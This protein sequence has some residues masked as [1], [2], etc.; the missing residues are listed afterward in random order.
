L[1]LNLYEHSLKE[2][3][4][5]EGETITESRAR[6]MIRQVLEGLE[7]L[8]AREP[9]I[10]HRD[11]KPTNIL[12]DVHGNL[13]LSDFGIGRFFPEQGIFTRY[14]FNRSIEVYT[15]TRCFE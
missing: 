7:A 5:E 12:I 11:L 10:L 13:L 6:N 1:I 2:F 14:I 3:I 15:G 4:R 9:R 8:H